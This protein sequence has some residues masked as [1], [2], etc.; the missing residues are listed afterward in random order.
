VY[1]RANM[2]VKRHSVQRGK[3]RYVYL[4]L[5]EAFRTESGQVRHRVLANLGREDLLKSSGQLDQLAASF[6]RLDPPA[7]GTRR[8]VGT[9]LLVQH[10]LNKLELAKIVDQ[11]VPMRGR[12][13]LTHG[14]VISALV[15]NRLSAP[16][17]LYDV[18]G[19][20]SS[21]AMA[22][23]FHTPAELLNDDRLGRALEA[24][25]PVAEQVRSAA[26]LTAIRKCDV[27]DATRL[28]L[29]LTTVRFSGAYERSSLVAKG[30]GADRR[31]ARQIRAE[32]ATTSNGVS[33][34]FRPHPGSCAE[35]NVL[36]QALERLSKE[37]PAAPL[38]VADSALGHLGNLCAA[39]RTG[40]RFIV[41]LRANTGWLDRFVQ[42]VG[43]LDALHDLDY[44]SQR[45]QTF[46]PDRRT[47]WRG[48][49]QPWPV[50]DPV[51]ET[52][53]DLRVAFIW[54]SEE[55]ASVS[56]AR[57]RALEKACAAL[58][59]IGNGLGRRYY[60]TQQTVNAKIT[61]VVDPQLSSLIRI[62]TGT[63]DSGKPTLE[64][65]LDEEAIREAG[66]FDGLY[67]VATN[68]CDPPH[69]SLTAHDVLVLYKDQWLVEQRHRDLKQTLR[70]RP[71]FLHNDDRIL[72]LAS[73][74]G[75]ALLVFSL[76]EADLRARLDDKRTLPGLLPERRA[77]KPTGRSILNAFA[78]L[79]L[80]YTRKGIAL[81]PLTSTQRQ[82]LELLNIPLPWLE[83]AS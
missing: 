15:A 48:L 43:A 29:D 46:P 26:A 58:T 57:Q 47:R 8:E 28:H 61:K 21:S 77:A 11:A 38:V 81:D 82:I 39:H 9:L 49:L 45:E 31:V 34:Y 12:A 4:R 33:L 55:A 78:G 51:T 67:A 17:P 22:E 35:V 7:V 66:R 74:L 52:P 18:A 42:D 69:R 5:V 76:I 63:D 62:T 30:W 14:E 83:A 75:L 59:R 37:L 32:Q 80:T 56:A 41:P 65:T 16:S 60:K 3:N 44:V 54:S 2:Y 23:L 40:A 20:A 71:V 64:W 24:L 27:V 70:V 72:A 19:W 50:V 73:V 53:I 79:G 13:F 1:R 25:A 68:L 10:Y 36:S 6:T